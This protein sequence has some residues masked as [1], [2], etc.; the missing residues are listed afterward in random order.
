[1]ASLLRPVRSL[2]LPL[3]IALVA[4]A[5]RATIVP[6]L[7]ELIV[8][9]TVNGAISTNPQ[10]R[11]L[12]VMNASA[13]GVAASQGPK[14]FGPW[15]YVAPQ[16]GWDFPFYLG[17]NIPQA[18]LAVSQLQTQTAPVVLEPS[19]WTDAFVLS[20]V[21]GTD[22]VAHYVRTN[23][24][25]G[26]M[27]TIV[28]AQP[29][30]LTQGVDWLLSSS[31]GG[32][33]KTDTWQLNLPLQT[34]NLTGM[35]T[36]NA[37]FVTQEIPPANANVSQY[38]YTGPSGWIIDQWNQAPNV[39]VTLSLDPSRGIVSQTSP[40]GATP[41]Y[42]SQNIPFGVTPDDVTLKSYSTQVK[43]F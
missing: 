28:A 9:L 14:L 1:M 19:T 17:T 34:Y 35:S 31:S 3:S 10:V 15:V 20:S 41:V 40:H 43:Q 26:S 37:N 2:S 23:D 6:T 21:A 32:S 38:G 25:S 11:Y 29:P 8:Q 4:C 22:Q 39:Y 18:S 7:N 16:I 27:T 36:V 24:A 13:S 42:G 5:N 33:G 12:F 30:T